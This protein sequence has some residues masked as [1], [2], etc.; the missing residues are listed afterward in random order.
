MQASKIPPQE[1]KDLNHRALEPKYYDING[2]WGRDLGLGLGV[3]R[4]K[5][6]LP[7]EPKEEN[8]LATMVAL[9]RTRLR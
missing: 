6:L 9:H 4:L 7:V 8:I 2:I 5:G 3:R 1:S